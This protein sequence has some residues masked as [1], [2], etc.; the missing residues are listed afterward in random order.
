M[1]GRVLL[2]HGDGGK[3]TRQ[4]IEELILEHLGNDILAPLHDSALLGKIEGP[5]AF[6]TDS[7]VVSPPFFPGGD[8]GKLAVCGTVNDLAVSGAR[9][10]AISL[11]LIL[12]EG[13]SLSELSKILESVR[14]ATEVASIKVVCGDTKVVERGKG[15]GIFI[16]TAGVGTIISGWKPRLEEVKPGDKVLISGHIGEHGIAVLV[17]REKLKLSSP[18]SSDV[19]PL[20]KMLNEL[21]EKFG[22]EILFMRDPTRGGLG[23]TLNEIADRIRGTIVLHESTIPVRES[24]RGVSE[25][26]GFDPIYLAN[27]GKA[28]LVVREKAWERILEEMKRHEHGKFASVAGEITEGKSGVILKT[29]IGGERALD[30]PVGEQVPRIC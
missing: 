14:E 22:D 6:T 20:A 29:A 5:L 10:I 26:L 3:R 17:A 21:V 2:S 4:L 16:N 25:L 13:L 24:V 7:Y 30:Y 23:V 28:V 11:S 8:I 18:V 12:E 27:E 15:D 1:K 19:A 9:P